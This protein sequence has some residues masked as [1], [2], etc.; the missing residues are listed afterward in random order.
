MDPLLIAGRIGEFDL[1]QYGSIAARKRRK[2]STPRPPS[3]E[4][5]HS[6]KHACFRCLPASHSHIIVTAAFAR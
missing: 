5:K 6:E 2:L 3:G 4:G 1:N